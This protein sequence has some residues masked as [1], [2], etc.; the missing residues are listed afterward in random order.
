MSRQY[1]VFEVLRLKAKLERE[2][3]NREQVQKLKG[4][5]LNPLEQN[6]VDAFKKAIRDLETSSEIS[7]STLNEFSPPWRLT[8][9]QQFPG[10]TGKKP[11]GPVWPPEPLKD[12][13]WEQDFPPEPPPRFPW[14][15]DPPFGGFPPR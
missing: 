13:P 6:Q 9:E 12:K 1:D 10:Q 7:G 4:R 11:L 15:S 5:P 14:E 3:K 8:L 2:V